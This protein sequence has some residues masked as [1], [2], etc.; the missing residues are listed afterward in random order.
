MLTVGAVATYIVTVLL[1]G[2]EQFDEL[3]PITV[4]VCVPAESELVEYVLDVPL[5]NV[6]L[7]S[8]KEY[9]DKPL[10]AVKVTLSPEQIVSFEVLKLGAE[11]T[12]FSFNTNGLLVLLHLFE[13]VTSTV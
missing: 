1:K 11:G 8:R 9:D 12:A 5:F 13:L 2:L 6:V 3:V 7:P 4:I 10:A